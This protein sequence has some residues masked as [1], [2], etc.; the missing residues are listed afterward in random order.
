[1]LCALNLSIMKLYLKTDCEKNKY[2]KVSE[3]EIY[4]F[5][6]W[7]VLNKNMT[8]HSEFKLQQRIITIDFIEFVK[9]IWDKIEGKKWN[10]RCEKYMKKNDLENV[11]NFLNSHINEEFLFIEEKVL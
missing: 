11:V 9:S 3:N 10:E 8:I 2:P 4:L 6:F 5:S 1:M 7:Y